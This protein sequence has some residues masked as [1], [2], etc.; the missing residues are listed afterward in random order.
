MIFTRIL[1]ANNLR[2]ALNLLLNI[3][4]TK[5]LLLGLLEFG[6]T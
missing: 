1:V 4:V 2:I 6:Y 3:H 5:R